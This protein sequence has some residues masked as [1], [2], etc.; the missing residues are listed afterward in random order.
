[1]F[2]RR[3]KKLGRRPFPLY[4][5]ANVDVSGDRPTFNRLGSAFLDFPGPSDVEPRHTLGIQR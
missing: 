1:M 5:P 4:L 3:F 2:Q